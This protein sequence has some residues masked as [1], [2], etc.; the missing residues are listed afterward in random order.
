MNPSGIKLLLVSAAL[1]A[2][3]SAQATG[4][5][6]CESGSRSDWKTEAQLIE[7]ITADGWVVHKVK[8]DGG[9]YEVYGRDPQDR[10]VNLTEHPRR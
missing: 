2:S 8:E 7:K 3:A 5:M 1:L 4:L 9:C 6:T 10:R